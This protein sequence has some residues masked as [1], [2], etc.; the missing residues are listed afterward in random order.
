MNF[1]QITSNEVFEKIPKKSSEAMIDFMWSDVLYH[2]GNCQ[3]ELKNKIG[4]GHPDVL[5]RYYDNLGDKYVWLLGEYKG[6]ANLVITYDV[7]EGQAVV[8]TAKYTPSKN[9]KSGKYIAFG[10]EA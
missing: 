1:P 8:A 4:V 3:I 7:V 2:L 9:T 5:L 6:D 10:I